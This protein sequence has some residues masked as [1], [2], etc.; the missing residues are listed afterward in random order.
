MHKWDKIL[1]INFLL[2]GGWMVGLWDFSDSPIPNSDFTTLNLTFGD[3][4]LGFGLRILSQICHYSKMYLAK[5]YCI[6]V[7]MKFLKIQVVF[8]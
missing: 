6:G 4:G 2:Q 7:I 5:H 3:L 8:E 1:I